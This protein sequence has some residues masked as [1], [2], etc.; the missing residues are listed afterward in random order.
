MIEQLVASGLALGSIY[1]LLALSLVLINKAT[2]VVN[3]AQ[4]EIAMF[5]TFI[6]FW[7]LTK[8]GIPLVVVLILAAPIGAL[9]GMFTER[10][11]MRPLQ[12]A[13]QVN[14]L[15]ATIGLWMIFHHAAGWIWGYDPVRFPSLFSPEPVDV[16][17]AR[18]AQNSLGIIGVS[19]L[20]VVM[21]YLFFE[22]TRTGI[23]MRAASMNRRAAQ[24]MGVNVGRIA[25]VAWGL[26]TAIAVVAGFLIAP[27][28]F[29]DFEMMFAVLLKAF[30]GAILGGFN[31]L[32]G[33]VV[34]CLVIGVLENLFSAYVSTA[35]KDAFAFGIIVAVLMFRPQGLF[36]RQI[37]KK[38]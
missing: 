34:G 26:A 32:P 17:G 14:A 25:L 30:A 24:L 37:A 29:L 1:A 23:A 10:V 21:L 6:C 15:I 27:L 9:L 35:F 7:L 36:T 12:A 5:G 20:V 33:A 3:F 28:T 4:G 22:H 16:F 31:S 19:F 13:P 2:D 8:A 38:V 18:I 11:A